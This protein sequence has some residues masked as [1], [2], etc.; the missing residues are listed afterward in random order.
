MN[1]N[2]SPNQGGP[3]N[4]FY[5]SNE[6]SPITEFKVPEQ[7]SSKTLFV[8]I[9]LAILLIGG[10]TTFAYFEKVG[11]FRES[12]YSEDSFFSALL[13]KYSEIDSLSSSF[14]SSFSVVQRD[15]DAKPFTTSISN[16]PELREKYQNDAQ[17]AK[18]V[19]SIISSLRYS[20]YSYNNKSQN[21]PSSLRGIENDF[22]LYNSASIKD[23]VSGKEYQY[24]VTENG[25]NFALKVNFET[26]DAVS[27]IKKSYD[28]IATST[29]IEGNTV[30]F[31]KNSPYYFYLSSEP[32]KP[33]LIDLQELVRELPPDINASLSMSASSDLKSE[34]SGWSFNINAE[35]DFGD[36]TYKVNADALKKDADYYFR[37][38]NIPSLFLFGDLASLKGK[39]VKIPTEV[40]S[41]SPNGSYSTIGYLSKE[42]PEY[43]KSYK[44]N[45]QNLIELTKKIVSIADS[46]KIIL[47]KK[48]P[49]NE[50]IDGRELVRY[51]LSIRKEAILPFYRK[52]VDLIE[53]D[54]RFKEFDYFVDQ[55][56]I[57]YLQSQE[58]NE[59][60]DYYDKNVNLVFWTDREGFPA[61][62]E[63]TIRIVPPDTATQLAD[64]QMNLVFKSVVKDI[65][66]PLNIIAPEGAIL[67]DQVMKDFEK[68]MY[69]YDVSGLS[70]IKSNL[71][72]LRVYAELVYDTDGGY[73]KKAFSLGS[74]KKTASTLFGDNDVYSAINKATDNNPSK[75]T[76]VSKLSSGRVNSYA[77]S[78]P[79]PD[80]PQYSW[81]VDSNGVSKQIN[82]SIKKDS[83]D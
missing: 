21:Y 26:R 51:E 68:N 43:E 56:M 39:W 2:L 71:S 50:K 3:V 74:C 44:E 6:S 18:D 31:T 27:S 35:G 40:S 46:E 28:Y 45:K 81:C 8:A 20:N 82:G 69:E 29:I 72:T 16:T 70:S 80:S 76:C 32:P 58:F 54:T 10:V 59:V 12:F 64:K 38:N 36:L 9:F 78:V 57:E 47:F 61:M 49:T 11:P 67:I 17:R 1:D 24:S 7:K 30:T 14:T 5:T 4:N 41:S 15:K 42:I 25:K 19:S 22:G 66:K 83:C 79:L 52:V 33:L 60:F 23:P 13:M 55:G 63:V 53:S 34:N 48:Q 73:G 62:S 75:A 65:N 37:I 77:I